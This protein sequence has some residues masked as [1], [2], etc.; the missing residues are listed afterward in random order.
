MAKSLEL[1]NVDRE[2]KILIAV[3]FRS[4]LGSLVV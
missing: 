1:E 4:V 2:I 3:G